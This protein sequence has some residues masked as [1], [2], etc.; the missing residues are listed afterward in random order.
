[1]SEEIKKENVT[2]EESTEPDI[3]EY[4]IVGEENY[5]TESVR[6]GIDSISF[7]L[8]GVAIAD[9]V[10]KFS[11]VTELQV[12]D[13]TLRPY[14][15]YENLVFVSALVDVDTNVTVTMKKKNDLEV[16]V[17]QLQQA[18]NEQAVAIA[19]ILYGGGEA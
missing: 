15:S 8:E 16:E 14:G 4:V 18:V 2:N 6:T 3:Y 11:E 19:D 1:M 5:K 17:E 10:E 12:S 13:S 9:A 7:V